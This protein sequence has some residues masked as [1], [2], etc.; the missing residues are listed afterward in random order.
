MINCLY[1][2][3]NET[4]GQ[5]LK[6]CIIILFLNSSL[7]LSVG[8]AFDF[9][10]SPISKIKQNIGSHDT[11]KQPFSCAALLSNIY[12]IVM[13]RCTYSLFTVQVEE[14]D[15]AWIPDSTFTSQGMC[16]S[17]RLNVHS[18]G[19]IICTKLSYRLTAVLNIWFWHAF[20]VQVTLSIR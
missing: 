4:K 8:V 19:I 1:C 17:M 15:T 5:D 16:S 9:S 11:F 12:R 3:W 2:P 10:H 14:G 13:Y 7:F 20:N 18:W 6:A